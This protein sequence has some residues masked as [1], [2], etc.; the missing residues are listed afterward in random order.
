MR[1][2]DLDPGTRVDRA[3]G[4]TLFFALVVM[5]LVVFGAVLALR[6]DPDPEGPALVPVV[7]PVAE[8][9]V[10]PV[11]VEPQDAAAAFVVGLNDTAHVYRDARW[12]WLTAVATPA[13]AG[14][15]E[16]AYASAM[17]IPD[18]QAVFAD[19]ANPELPS[20]GSVAPLGYRIVSVAPGESAEVDVWA[21]HFLSI[22][23]H[24]PRVW[25]TTT[26][27]FLEWNGAGWLVTAMELLPGPSPVEDP[28][29]LFVPAAEGFTPYG[30]S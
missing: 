21:G 11:V 13:A 20:Y 14:E 5:S 29:D 24:E 16:A 30:L 23:G 18:V 17:Q 19:L 9:E 25:W 12:A 4:G 15:I 7:E 6:N 28:P 10:L 3:L 8:P 27:T 2:E 26:R 22:A 1:R